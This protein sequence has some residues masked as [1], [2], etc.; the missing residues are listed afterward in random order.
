[1]K[2]LRRIRNFAEMNVFSSKFSLNFDPGV[3]SFT[4][5]DV[6]LS[7]AINGAR[8]LEEHNIKGTFYISLG[9]ASPDN[10]RYRLL[11]DY[12]DGD[13]MAFVNENDVEKL[14]QGGHHIGCHSFSHGWQRAQSTRKT[15]ADCALNERALS[16]ITRN[17]IVHFSYPYGEISLLA[18]REL[19]R[20]YKTMRSVIPGINFGLTDLSCLK[21]ISIASSRLD[22]ESFPQYV[23]EAREKN[24]WLILMTHEVCKEP[25]L[26]GTTIDDFNWVVDV[27]AKSD[28][29]V[30]SIDRAYELL[31]KSC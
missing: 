15:L 26:W 27:V 11:Q 19:R 8:I 3:I 21:T 6:P 25:N 2:L 20:T 9:L 29:R 10:S 1:M 22:R 28:C 13:S 18:K 23:A 31:E 7:G 4:F 24:G 16:G 5:D 14:M 12:K 17:K 30:L